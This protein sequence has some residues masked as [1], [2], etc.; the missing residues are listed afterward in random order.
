MA[1]GGRKSSLG[2]S[3]AKTSDSEDFLETSE[4]GKKKIEPKVSKET[5]T[6]K[7][8]EVQRLL[9]RNSVILKL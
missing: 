3:Q 7:S 5:K 9:L 1:L 6:L 4:N 2:E 8:M